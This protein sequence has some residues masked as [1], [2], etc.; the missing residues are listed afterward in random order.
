MSTSER[1]KNQIDSAAKAA[2]LDK[3]KL[4]RKKDGSKLFSD[5]EHNER[6]AKINDE[7]T[8]TANEVADQLN[9]LIEKQ[10]AELLNLRHGDPTEILS[11]GELTVANNKAMF[12]REDC[13]TLPLPELANRLRA[14]RSSGSPVT[15]WL[16]VRYGQMRMRKAR[17]E[18]GADSTPAEAAAV[19]ELEY[20]VFPTAHEALKSV[21]AE[22]KSAQDAR[23]Y[24]TRRRLEIDGTDQRAREL[25]RERVSAL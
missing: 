9:E 17:G 19:H 20:V 10:Q 6:I 4:Y 7:F 22:I 5:E 12:V 8:R 2:E 25:Q 16:Y 23:H 15:R 3:A 11:G 18:L 1:L 13:E 21:E 14:I 24:I